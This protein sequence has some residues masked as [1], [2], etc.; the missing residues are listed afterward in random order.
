MFEIKVTPEFGRGL[1]ATQKIHTN[2]I[3]EVSEILVLSQ[4]DTE[5]VNETELQYYTFV[6]NKDTLQD[7]LV[8]GNGEIFN[9]VDIPNVKYD[10]VRYDD[11]FKMVFVSVQDIEAGEQLFIDYNRDTQVDTTQ[12]VDKNMVG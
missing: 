9:H 7:C 8:L 5:F 3:I 4:R 2:Q 12:Y 10:L 1:Y 6:F 11:R